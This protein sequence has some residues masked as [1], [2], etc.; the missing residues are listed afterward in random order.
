[1]TLDTYNEQV[2]EIRIRN[3]Q[4]NALNATYAVTEML[5]FFQS[6]FS[7]TYGMDC[8]GVRMPTEVNTF[9]GFQKAV[10]TGYRGVDGRI[11]KW[12]FKKWDGGHGLDLYGS[13]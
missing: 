2:E 4:R 5:N 3:K 9:F 11:L 8:F 1:M 7:A 13:G 10:Q 6:I 12:I